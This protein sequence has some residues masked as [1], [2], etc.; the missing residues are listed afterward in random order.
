VSTPRNC[1]DGNPC[2]AD[3]CDPE[4]GCVQTDLLDGSSCADA[5]L[6]DGIE[7][8]SAGTCIAGVPPDCDDGG[9]CTAD[10]CVNATGCRHTPL[11]GCCTTDAQC[12]DTDECTVNEVCTVQHTCVS[13]PRFC[14]DG[15]V[16]TS[17]GCN[18]GSGCTHVPTGGGSCDEGNA[19]T[20]ADSCIGGACVGTPVS[21]S[22]G[23]LCN[24]LESCVLPGGQCAPAGGPP[25]C[26][27]GGGRNERACAAEWH[28]ANP[29]NPAGALPITQL[30]TQGNGSCDFDAD[31]G[32][33]TFRVAIC[34]RVP[35]SR[36]VPA[37]TLDDVAAYGLH[38]PSLRRDPVT[39]TAILAALDALPGS[40]VGTPRASDVTFVPPLD[41]ARCTAPVPIVV[42]VGQ[43]MSMSARIT[44]T[45]GLTDRDRLRLVC[46]PF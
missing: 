14:D 27:P 24:G 5:N 46:V 35:D 15:N 2:T 7:T 17:D 21:C 19:C 6:C 22:D 11:A 18:P 36:L 4:A 9:A 39:A 33:C 37:C 12:A 16:C 8:C 20:S 40:T 42:P 31:P 45:N 13:S 28:V 26:T 30:C 10:S 32:T 43:R 1:L 38:R 3:A 34:F 41:V 44:L 29:D 23:N 25:T